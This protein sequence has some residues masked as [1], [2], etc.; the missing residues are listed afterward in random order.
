MQEMDSYRLANVFQ[1]NIRPIRFIP[2]SRITFTTIV[3]TVRY[4]TGLSLK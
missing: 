1:N 4:A 2:K 3:L